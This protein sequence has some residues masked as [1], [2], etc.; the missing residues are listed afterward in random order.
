MARPTPKDAATRGCADCASRPAHWSAGCSTTPSP[1]ASSRRPPQTHALHN[2][3][4]AWRTAEGPLSPIAHEL[5]MHFWAAVIG[6]LMLEPCRGAGIVDAEA[7][8]E[9]YLDLLMAGL[10]FTIE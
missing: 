9:S 10:G 3:T 6:Y 8:F 5:T 1:P 2:P 4:E 7:F